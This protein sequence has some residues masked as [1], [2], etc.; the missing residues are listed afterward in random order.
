[1][2]YLVL[3]LGIV[4]AYNNGM[5]DG[6]T[7]VATSISSRLIPPKKAV[8]MA[9]LANILGALLLG[10]AVAKTMSTSIVNGGLALSTGRNTIMALLIATFIG[11]LLWNVFTFFVKMPSSASHSLIGA[12]VG[13]YFAAFGY[14]GVFWDAFFIKIILAMVMSPFLGFA[15]AFL[16]MKIS[17][18]L[19]RDRSIKWAGRVRFFHT[20]TTFCLAFA[21]GSNDSQKI[22]GLV[23]LG[24]VAHSQV[25]QVGSLEFPFWLIAI[26]GSSLALGTLTGGYNM[27][28]TVGKNITKVNVDSSFISQLSTVLIVI[29]SNLWGLPISTTQ[30]IT[31]SVLG[32]GAEKR[33]STVNW[34]VMKKI[35]LAWVFTIPA[36]A[37]SG[38]LLYELC[39]SIPIWSII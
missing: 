30:I 38:Y 19:M 4:F 2:I 10:T 6:G 13:A 16:M 20:L 17:Y 22:I 3:A 39:K 23:G 25:P 12:M 8:A 37:L 14:K 31:G 32:V 5:H 27:I 18:Y 9:A 11:S 1:M 15:L 36:S 21:Y 7:I 28:G 29:A 34:G 26:T 33:P 35:A 24:L